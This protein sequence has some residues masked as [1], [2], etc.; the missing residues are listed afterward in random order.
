MEFA[1]TGNESRKQRLLRNA[2]D[3]FFFSNTPFRVWLFVS[4][5]AVV[6]D[7]RDHIFKMIPNFIECGEPDLVL[8][9]VVQQSRN[10]LVFTTT[11]FQY[12]ASDREQVGNIRDRSALTFLGCVKLGCHNESRFISR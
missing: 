12:Q 11:M 6:Y 7:L 4:I 9:G 10:Y 2:C 1:R 3:I 5:C 8:F